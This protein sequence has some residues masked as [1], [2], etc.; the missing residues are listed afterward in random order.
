MGILLVA[1]TMRHL[2]PHCG[3]KWESRIRHI[4]K[5]GIGYKLKL[6]KQALPGETRVLRIGS[7]RLDL[8]INH[9]PPVTGALGVIGLSGRACKR[10]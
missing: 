10:R 2:E 4:E 1:R 7:L 8:N 3:L 6:S 5:N 9:T